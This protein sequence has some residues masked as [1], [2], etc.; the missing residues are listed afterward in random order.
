MKEDY[1]F[2]I[3]SISRSLGG[4]VAEKMYTGKETASAR[5]DLEQATEEAR[6]M[7]VEYGLSREFAFR[8]CDND[9]VLMDQ[10]HFIFKII[11]EIR[12]RSFTSQDIFLKI[13]LEEKSKKH[14]M[15]NL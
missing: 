1:D 8:N 6:S 2:F 12:M 10:H 15:E 5:S 7:I 4:R 13:V 3:D 9:R 14:L 11:L